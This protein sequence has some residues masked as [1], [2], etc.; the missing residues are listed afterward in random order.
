MRTRDIFSYSFGAIRLRK[1][2]S[3]LTT[4]GIVIGIA[5]IVALMSYT[6]GFEIAITN[7]FTEGFSTDTVTVS[8]QSFAFRPGTASE[9]SDFKLYVDD[10]AVIQELSYVEYVS[11]II[12]KQAV[13]NTTEYELSLSVTGIDFDSYQEIYS[14]TFTAASG[15]IPSDPGAYDAVIGDSVSDP[16]DNGTLFAD[17][18]DE[19]LIK[20]TIINGTLRTEKNISVT[21]VGILNEIGGSIGGPSDMGVYLPVSTAVDFFE[22]TEVNSIIVQLSDDSE[23][24]IDLAIAEIGALFEGEVTVTSATAIL[25]QLSTMI[26]TIELLLGGIAAISLLVAGI[27]IMNIMIVSIMERT[28]EIGILKA[29]GAKGSTVLAVFL[30]EA[31]MIG[32]FGGVFGIITGGV[33]ALLLSGLLGGFNTG[34]SVGSGGNPL[35]SLGTITPVLTIDLILMALFFGI[36]VSVLFALY[37]ARRAAHLQPVDALRNE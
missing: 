3:G 32:I 2:R 26:G 10:T 24:T 16:W 34:M 36:V 18:G 14:S 13:L 15:G 12:N 4:L 33:I 6:Q 20:Y 22:T 35:G 28:R 11:P 30:A 9:P 1:I 5:A 29:L 25:D 27:G 8:T 17:I 37:P 23:D 31:T 21:V 7:Q 19:F